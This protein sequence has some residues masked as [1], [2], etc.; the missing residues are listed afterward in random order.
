MKDKPKR[1]RPQV[2][3]A[4][5]PMPFRVRKSVIEMSKYLGRDA[6]ED[7]IIQEFTQ[8]CKDWCECK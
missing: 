1:G 3:D 2:E 8:R 5:E 4:R 6:V 7:L